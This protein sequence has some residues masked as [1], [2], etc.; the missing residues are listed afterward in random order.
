MTSTVPRFI[1]TKK[2]GSIVRR[3]LAEMFSTTCIEPLSLNDLKDF[4]ATDYF[5][6]RIR[7]LDDGRE[8][9]FSKQALA[10]LNRLVDVLDDA[11]HPDPRFNW[12]DINTAVRKVCEQS[13]KAGLAPENLDELLPLLW[14]VL[15]DDI[16]SRTFVAALEGVKLL[17]ASPLKLGGL[18]VSPCARSVIQDSGVE[19]RDY[20]DY[21]STKGFAESVCIHGTT[22]GTTDAALS[23]FKEQANLAAAMLAVDAG[24]NYERAATTFLIEARTDEGS[25]SS[26]GALFYWQTDDTSKYTLSLLGGRPQD[27]RLTGERVQQLSAS[28]TFQHAFDVFQRRERN[29][30]EEAFVRAVYWYGDAH[31][32]KTPVMQFVKYWSCLECLLGGPGEQLTD[33]LAR[34]TVALLVAGP[35]NILHHDEAAKHVKSVK[36]LYGLRSKAVHRAAHAHVSHGDIVQ[37]STWSALAITNSLAI[38]HA[39]KRSIEALWKELERI[40]GVLRISSPEVIP[41]DDGRTAAVT[42]QK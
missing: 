22:T 32:D 33:T 20:L 14:D 8:V 16:R 31:T 40:S 38:I 28:A 13:F 34:N 18:M 24:A 7:F 21:P 41:E 5:A 3:C 39:G 15:R 10:A 35:Y 2:Q 30:L 23:W 37:M 25:R 36:R 4:A 17:G 19:P 11:T 26:A 6:R 42:K 29:S 27:L 12:S 1:F 9:L